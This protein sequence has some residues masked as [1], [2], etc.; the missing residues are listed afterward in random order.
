MKSF[1]I[2]RTVESNFELRLDNPDFRD[3]LFDSK[4]EVEDVDIHVVEDYVEKCLD[5]EY[6]LDEISDDI[7]IEEW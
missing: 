3:Y 2:T 5:I 4:I 1:I 7:E 6:D